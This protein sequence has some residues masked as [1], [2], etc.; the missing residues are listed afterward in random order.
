MVNR[1]V[2]GDLNR[3]T[4]LLEEQSDFVRTYMA[5]RAAGTSCE[6]LGSAAF[7]AL[8]FGLIPGGAVVGVGSAALGITG[9]L[10]NLA[11]GYQDAKQTRAFDEK[12]LACLRTHNQRSERLR[13]LLQTW[14]ENAEIMRN[15]F[16]Q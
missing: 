14:H 5:D 15:C 9:K 16:K 13:K 4:D 8:A 11:A 3:M 6:F 1:A 2:Q 7:A 10:W 12:A